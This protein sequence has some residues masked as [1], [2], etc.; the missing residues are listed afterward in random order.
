MRPLDTLWLRE[1]GEAGPLHLILP[2]KN[3]LAKERKNTRSLRD[4]EA[5]HYVSR[6][7]DRSAREGHPEP[8][9]GIS[10]IPSQMPCPLAS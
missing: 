5:P 1:R 8:G 9:E 2:E 3:L 7:V 4:G 10:L 6:V